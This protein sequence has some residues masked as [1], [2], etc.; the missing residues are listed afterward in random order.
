MCSAPLG[1]ETMYFC[2][3]RE[4]GHESPPMVGLL[5]W[6]VPPLSSNVSS[7]DTISFW[8][9]DLVTSA[10]HVCCWRDLTAWSA[11]THTACLTALFELV[12]PLGGLTLYLCHAWGQVI[13]S[14]QCTV[15]QLI[16]NLGQNYFFSQN[17]LFFAPNI[18]FCIEI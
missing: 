11:S 2:H 10:A 12:N 13:P 14:P 3:A 5:L 17:I 16:T 6:F 4:Q 9:Y 15:G 7:P 8:L 1:A 18:F